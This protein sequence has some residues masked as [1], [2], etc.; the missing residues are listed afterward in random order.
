MN[1]QYKNKSD[2]YLDAANDLINSQNHF[3]IVPH[4]AYYS[5]LLLIEHKCYIKDQKTEGDIRPVVNGIRPALHDGLINYMKNYLSNSSNRSAHADCR[6][7][8]SKITDLKKLRVKADYKNEF[9]TLGDGQKSFELAKEII[10]ILN[11]N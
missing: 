7:F 9:I 5:C 6:K 4:T 3:M 1:S 8:V 2:L 11:K 10:E